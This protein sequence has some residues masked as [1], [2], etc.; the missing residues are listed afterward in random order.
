[1]KIGKKTVL[2]GILVLL[3]STSLGF[4][5]QAK[6]PDRTVINFTYTMVAGVPERMWF[7][8]EDILMCRNTPHDGEV[9]WSDTDFYG[10]V[11]YSGNIKLNMVTY[12]GLGGGFFELTG[13]YGEGAELSLYGRLNFKIEFGY[14]TGTL[15][16]HGTG[17]LE[18]KLLK[19]TTEGMI[20]GTYTGQLI[21]WN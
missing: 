3:C 18:G 16:L 12:C 8:L 14:L 2:L 4:M 5:V 7:P 10:D 9:K 11:F 20:G 19:G 21:I 15:N 17:A 1:M 13:F 6:P